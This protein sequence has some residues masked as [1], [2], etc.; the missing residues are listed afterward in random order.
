MA[1]RLE[2]L[3]FGTAAVYLVAAGGGLFGILAAVYLVAAWAFL[4]ALWPIVRGR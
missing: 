3:I 2:L 1:T 4:R